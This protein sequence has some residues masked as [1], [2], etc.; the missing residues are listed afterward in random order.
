M[1]DIKTWLIHK[2]KRGCYMMDLFILLAKH[3][4]ETDVEEIIIADIARSIFKKSKKKKKRQTNSILKSDGEKPKA[5][6]RRLKEQAD[7]G[8]RRDEKKEDD[9]QNKPGRKGFVM[10]ARVPM[11]SNQDYVVR[12]KVKQ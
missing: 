11:P 9:Q 8:R 12:P 2:G 5:K 10:R 3:V 6:K 7:S 1:Y 4:V